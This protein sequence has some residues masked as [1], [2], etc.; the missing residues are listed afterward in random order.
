M[1]QR[2][3]LCLILL[4]LAGFAGAADE[5]SA[6]VQDFEGT[7]LPGKYPGDA[8]G[9]VTLSTAWKSDGKQSLRIDPGLNS[10]VEQ[11]KPVDWSAHNTLR[12]HLKYEGK[13][14]AQ[15]GFEIVDAI[16]RE[17]Y[18]N[19]HL[20]SF[21]L[22]PGEQVIDIDY[23][24]GIYRGE[25]T[26]KFRGP[27]KMPVDVTKI[28]RIGFTNNGTAALHID[29]MEVVKVKRL[30]TPGGFAFDFGGPKSTVMSNFIGIVPTTRYAEDRGY[31][32]NGD[33]WT[34]NTE[35]TW[36]T[37]LLGDGLAFPDGGF[38]VDLP[39]GDYVGMIAFEKG[40][41]WGP[42]EGCAY[43][44]A[45]VKINGAVVTQHDFSQSAIHFMFQDVELTNIDQ[46][47]DKI[48]WPAN[49]VSRFTF[50]AAKGANVVTT[51]VRNSTL[52]KLRVAGLIVAPA[53]AEGKAFI[54]AHEQLQ[55]K[56]INETFGPVDKG[57]RD[58]RTAP[59]KPLVVETLA[60]GIE[61]FPRD[62]PTTAG[63]LPG[64]LHAVG[65]Q[66]VCVH[67]GVYAQKA[68]TVTVAAAPLK[69]GATAVG[70]AKASYGRYLPDRHQTGSTWLAINHYRPEPTF[71]VGPDLSRSLIV[72]FIIPADAKGGKATSSITLS[73]VGAPITIPV[74]V[75][76]VP[77]KLEPLPIP[78]GLFC[79]SMLIPPEAMDDATWWRLQESTLR[80]QGAAGLTALTGGSGLE[81]TLANGKL[82]GDRAVRFIKLAQTFGPI[83]GVTNYGGFHPGPAGDDAAN[84]AFAAAL[85]A[86]ED[87]EKLP[88]H[89]VN[90]YDEP[91]T[92]EAIAGVSGPLKSAFGAGLRTTGWTS[93][94]WDSAGWV[95]MIKATY[96]PAANGHE[97]DW[98]ERVKAFGRHPWI[99]NNGS[100][101]YDTGL[102]LWRQIKLG[103]EGRLDW[104]GFNTQGFAFHNLDGREPA[105]S[106]FAMHSTFGMLST[107][108]WLSRREG[109]LD[110]RLRLSLEKV[111]KADDPVLALWTLD[112][113]QKDSAHWTDAALQEARVKTLKRL[114]E[115]TKGK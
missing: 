15:M 115:L 101:R 16:G 100:T 92:D 113:Y 70:E 107:P 5:P 77:V 41:Y 9:E 13:E 110:C 66:T 38:R 14:P 96:A 111:A 104:I 28:Q 83:L 62:W 99:Y 31:G 89:Y 112:G 54:D 42:N 69:A 20:N 2:F 8:P 85:K 12:L 36:P 19:R 51:E 79:N 11:F 32:L 52:Q 60:P 33:G 37:N 3:A 25:P 68:G 4:G 63:S 50:K 27:A 40:G 98:F 87:S 17:N 47:A 84:Q 22:K 44:H 102:H 55:R 91:A 46:Y 86:L 45:A 94:H 76:I 61:I 95:E 24:G 90:S 10:V 29:R 49:S 30:E 48:V 56:A 58:G 34:L 103:C 57:R 23:A 106:H 71:T 35:M 80:E 64:D 7:Y 78:V 59:A 39:G 73:G 114:D 74:S 81:Y 53:T 97:R 82:S 18:W 109:L 1:S 21:A 43:D 105:M 75:Q 6:S 26:S 88:P 108:G 67:L 72:E 93:A 65:G